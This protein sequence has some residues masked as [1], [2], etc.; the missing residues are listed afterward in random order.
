MEANGSI[1]GPPVP[2]DQIVQQ[3]DHMN[4]N[5]ADAQSLMCQE[6]MQSKQEMLLSSNNFVPSIS[7]ESRLGAERMYGGSSRLNAAA[8]HSFS[9]ENASVSTQ[10]QSFL[11]ISTANLDAQSTSLKSQRATGTAQASDSEAVSAHQQRAKAPNRTANKTRRSLNDRRRDDPDPDVTVPRPAA[12]SEH[13][14]ESSI[15]IPVRLRSSAV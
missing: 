10:E 9:T 4:D 1:D 13:A 8:A 15:R 5:D 3:G 12:D 7:E 2:S 6:E 11:P 14:D